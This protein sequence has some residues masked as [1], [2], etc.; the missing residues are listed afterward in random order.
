MP[1]LQKQVLVEL[2]ENLPLWAQE[3]MVYLLYPDWRN[4]CSSCIRG[5]HGIRDRL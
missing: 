5:Y 3:R 1:G 2:G 4:T